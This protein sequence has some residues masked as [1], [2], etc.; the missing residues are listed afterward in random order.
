MST[1][2]S[3]SDT[4]AKVIQALSKKPETKADWEKVIEAAEQ[5]M[6]LSGAC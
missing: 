2:P 1:Q 3:F 6:K 5:M 4:R